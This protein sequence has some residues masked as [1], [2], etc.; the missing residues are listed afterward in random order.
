MAACGDLVLPSHA[1]AAYGN[2]PR[3]SPRILYLLLGAALADSE[4]AKCVC[5]QSVLGRC[6]MARV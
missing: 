5:Q 3:D 6:A 2:K 1:A 4:A